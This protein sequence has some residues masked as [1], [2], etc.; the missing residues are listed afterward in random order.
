MT[1][2]CKAHST[3]SN[4]R[5]KKLVSDDSVYCRHHFDKL[6]SRPIKER[7]PYLLLNSPQTSSVVQYGKARKHTNDSNLDRHIHTLNKRL[8]GIEE[9][10]KTIADFFKRY[11]MRQGLF[12]DQPIYRSGGGGH[13][14]PINSSSNQVEK[15]ESSTRRPYIPQQPS[16]PSTS[17]TEESTEKKAIPKPPPMKQMNPE[18]EKPKGG[19]MMD[20]VSE[21]K[22]KLAGGLKLR[23]VP[24]IPPKP[25]I[26][27]T[28]GK[29]KDDKNYYYHY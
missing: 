23:K 19:G 14:I 22:K 17:E 12:M 18:P 13:F 10:S 16:I 1:H 8:S 20:L 5:C 9:A 26:E 21:L 15:E 4:R 29:V 3:S 25:E 11:E 27:R 24:P 28:M 6:F 7:N 2:R